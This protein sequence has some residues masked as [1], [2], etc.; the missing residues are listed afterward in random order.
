MIDTAD[1]KFSSDQCR[2]DDLIRIVEVATDIS[3]HPRASRIEMGVPV[4]DSHALRKAD[5]GDPIAVRAELAT[6]LLNG[7]GIV[8]ITGAV[9]PD[10][11]DRATVAFE[12]MIAS[13]RADA[14]SGGDHFAAPGA[15][16][17]VW[18]AIQKLALADPA[19]FVDYYASDAIDIVARAWLGPGYQVTSQINLVNPGARRRLRIATTTLVSWRTPSLSSIRRTPTASRRC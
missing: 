15:N 2:L 9:T 13:Q 5:A 16:D 19:T 10:V 11:V 12:A 7:A 6:T 14:A 18:N 1:Q 17:R 4:Y 3:D 8:V